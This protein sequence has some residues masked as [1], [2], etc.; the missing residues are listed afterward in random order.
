SPQSGE[1][2]HIWNVELPSGPYTLAAVADSAVSRGVST[3]VEL[4]VPGTEET[5]TLYVLAV[6]VNDYPDRLRLNYASQD[7][8]AIAKALTDYGKSVFRSVEVKLI[9]DKDATTKGITDGLAWL[10]TKM[11]AQDVGVFF[12]SGHGAQ[13][14]KGEFA[15]VPVDVD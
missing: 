13:D 14:G 10:G 11:T 6:G 12:F 3:P 15:L 9:K 2:K 1:V 4:R 7:A 8:D 5:P